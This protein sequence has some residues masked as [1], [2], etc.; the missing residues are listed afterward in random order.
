MSVLDSEFGAALDAAPL[1]APRL[2][3]VANV[4]GD[5]VRTVGEV[6]EALKRQVAG[7][8]QWTRTVRRL[9]ADGYDT[10][11]EVGPGRALTGF[12]LKI[13]PDLPVH[14]VGQVRRINS[15]LASAR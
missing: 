11:V 9:A 13:V 4:T 3:V 14:S 2:P 15:L 12:S 1:A 8:V 5:Y 7:P 6:R 10:F